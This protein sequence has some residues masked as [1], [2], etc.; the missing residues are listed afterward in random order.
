MPE[1][2]TELVRKHPGEWLAVRVTKEENFEPVEGELLF[3]TPQREEL[4][5]NLTLKKGERVAVFF[6]GP[7]LKEGYYA[8]F[9]C[10]KG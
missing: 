6:A 8:A 9:A 7:P 2:I 4:Y 1:R 5:K 10:S 3:H